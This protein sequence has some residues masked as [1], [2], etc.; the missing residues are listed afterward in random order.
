[1]ARDDDSDDKGTAPKASKKPDEGKSKKPEEGKSETKPKDNGGAK[2]ADAKKAD[3]SGDKPTEKAPDK[4][5]AKSADKAAADKPAD[6][7]GKKAKEAKEAKARP[8]AEK[9]AAARAAVTAAHAAAHAH[10][11]H[12]PD[13][14]EYWKIFAVLFV[15]TVIEVLVAQVPG[16]GKGFMV[17]AL[18]GLALAK[19]ACVALFY[20]HLKHETK[21][22]RAYVALPFAAPAVYALVLIAEA[23][24]RLTR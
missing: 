1:M 23:A 17:S 5:A 9:P 13:R 2:P 10:G 12:A 18:V 8:A 16:I 19:A 21:V 24:W 7:S 6:R 11:H 15:L 4:S 14:K 22:L 20:M 3:K